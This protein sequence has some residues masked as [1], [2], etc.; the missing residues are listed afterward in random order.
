MLYQLSYTREPFEAGLP[1]A[2]LTAGGRAGSVADASKSIP[3]SR[4]PDR[5]VGVGFEPT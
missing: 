4:L 3:P 2:P 5:V 1:A